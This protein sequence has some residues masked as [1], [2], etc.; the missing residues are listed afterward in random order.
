[1]G[2]DEPLILTLAL[3]TASSTTFDALRRAHF[4]PARN[5]LDAHVTM[6][7][8]LRG[9]EEDVRQV[10][11]EAA[12]TRGPFPVAVTG[13]RSLGGGVAFELASP[14]LVAL[15]SE[16]AAR[17]AE[18]LT[19]QDRAGYRPHVTV[20]NKVPAEEA[21][22]LLARLRDGFVPWS[23]QGEGLALWRY[24]GG[25]WDHLETSPFSG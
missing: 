4:P 12:S 15:R 11:R 5:H 17:W 6:F 21:A 2:D 13:L 14:A 18:G 19:R 25:P 8:A 1:M 9:P 16:L 24:R 20:Q 7:H 10:V 22:A 3:D 23:A